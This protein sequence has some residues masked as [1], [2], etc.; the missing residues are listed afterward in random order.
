MKNSIIL[1]YLVFAGFVSFNNYII[2]EKGYQ[3]DYQFQN[4]TNNS[5]QLDFALTLP[6]GKSN[7]K[8]NHS[9]NFK[10]EMAY[11]NDA[12]NT[13]K[14]VSYPASNTYLCKHMILSNHKNFY[15]MDKFLQI[16]TQS[17]KTIL[18]EFLII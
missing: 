13:N 7:H 9:G 14:I 4:F 11:L 5:S 2:T 15:H 18:S 3:S 17:D 8:L 12:A 6:F 10:L 1:I 16:F